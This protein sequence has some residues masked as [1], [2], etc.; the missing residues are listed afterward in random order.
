MD[1]VIDNFIFILLVKYTLQ[2]PEGQ[3]QKEKQ[4]EK[5]KEIHKKKEKKGALRK[6]SFFRL[7]ALG[8]SP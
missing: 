5:K 3:K 1:K 6:P 7:R 4:P 8:L 2:S